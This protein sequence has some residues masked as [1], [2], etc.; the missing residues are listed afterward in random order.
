MYQVLNVSGDVVETLESKQEAWK[1]ANANEG[2]TVIN[3]PVKVNKEE[4]PEDAP[5]DAQSE[6]E[7][8]KGKK[9]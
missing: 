2:F 3:A 1:M 6:E 4:E 7:P 5:E 8:K 9:K